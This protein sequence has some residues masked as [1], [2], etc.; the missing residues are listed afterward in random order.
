M[1]QITSP[2]TKDAPFI[3]WSTCFGIATLYQISLIVGVIIAFG[4]ARSFSTFIETLPD[5]WLSWDAEHYVRIATYGY[6]SEGEYKTLIAFFPLF[7][8]LIRAISELIPT[9]YS[10]VIIANGCSLVGH[11]IFLRVLSEYT[12][13]MRG[14]I[15]CYALFLTTP[16]APLFTTG[17]TESLY[18]LIFSLFL[19][20]IQRRAYQGAVLMGFLASMTR[21][22]GIIT[23]APYLCTVWREE[24]SWARK[25][26]LSLFG[27]TICCGYGTYLML[28]HIHFGDLFYYTKVLEKFW[29]KTFCSPITRIYDQALGLSYEISTLTIEDSTMLLD[30]V[31]TFIALLLFAYCLYA[32][33]KK[34]V[35]LDLGNAIFVAGQLFVITSQSFWLSNTRYVA[36]IL[37]LYLLLANSF[38][39]CA[40][41]VY[42]LVAAS[43][44]YLPISFYLYV[45][46]LWFF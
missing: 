29:H 23:L 43:L 34:R 26:A 21:V 24:R 19:L 30:T 45:K 1:Q 3:P 41:I 4:M 2:R 6:E 10:A 18:L 28:N 14:I 37:P 22:V 12:R 15:A 16:I 46:Q 35:S 25:L 8:L 9:P 44:A 39:Q 42:F 27:G 5:L 11:A 40:Y 31:T 38:K 36:M 32:A 17:Y 33:Y 7:P 20:F 13:D